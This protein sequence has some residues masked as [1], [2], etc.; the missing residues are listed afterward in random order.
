M[1]GAREQSRAV[2]SE[3]PPFASRPET[4]GPVPDHFAERGQTRHPSRM[5]N[6]E[7][8]RYPLGPDPVH[9]A[10]SSEVTLG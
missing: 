2:V 5:Q 1:M 4:I 10:I 8:S 6:R 3:A 9:E 7:A